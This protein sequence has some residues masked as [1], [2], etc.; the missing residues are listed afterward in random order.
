MGWNGAAGIGLEDGG[1][2]GGREEEKKAYIYV[3][4]TQRRGWDGCI[5]PAKSSLAQERKVAW[6]PAGRPGAEAFQV[7]AVERFKTGRLCGGRRFNFQLITLNWTVIAIW[8][9]PPYKLGPEVSQASRRTKWRDSRKVHKHEKPEAVL[10]CHWRNRWTE[11][12]AVARNSSFQ[13][14][15]RGKEVARAIS[16]CDSKGKIFNLRLS[17]QLIDG[18]FLLSYSG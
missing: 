4:G 11:L 18:K 8:P 10:D 3:W 16:S 17:D 15:E 9:A 7:E 14:K 5:A 13:R 6:P 2:G 1:G 12:L